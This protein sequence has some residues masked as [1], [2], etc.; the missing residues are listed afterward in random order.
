MQ[1][2]KF[3]DLEE[4]QKDNHLIETGYRKLQ[5]SYWKCLQT[6]PRIHNETVNIVSNLLVLQ[7]ESS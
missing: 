7:A 3:K 6:I 5:G 1:L 4:W 2:L